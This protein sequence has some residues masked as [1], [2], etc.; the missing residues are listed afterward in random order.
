[1]RTEKEIR[2]KYDGMASPIVVAL[3]DPVKWDI[4]VNLLG[5]VLD[6][7]KNERYTFSLV[8]EEKK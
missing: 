7:P 1:M 3:T 5:W 8:E 2:E 4:I 6:I